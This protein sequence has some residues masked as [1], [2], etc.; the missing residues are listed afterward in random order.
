VR[1]AENVFHLAIPCRD[2]DEAF[3]YYVMK[4]GCKLARRYAD[5]ITLD[6]FGDQLVCHLYPEKIEQN[7]EMY[8]RHFGIT[9]RDKESFDRLVHLAQVREL[10]FFQPPTRRFQDMIE[11]HWT[12]MLIDPSNN[13][14]EFKYYLDPQ[15]MY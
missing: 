4:L 10:P 14:L 1:H 8:P 12:F 9:F 7:P 11:E 5:R 2:L 13:L 6:F 15:M 3:D